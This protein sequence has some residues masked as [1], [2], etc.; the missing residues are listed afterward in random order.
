MLKNKNIIKLLAIVLVLSFALVGCGG[1]TDTSEK[2]ADKG[3]V[4]ILYVEWA[5]ATA[6]SHVMAD[7]LEN[8]M[9]YKVELTPVSAP[10]LFEGLANGDADA[11]TTAWLPITHKSYM[12]KVT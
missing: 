10:L 5:C 1:T 11:M 7:I 6:S 2:V 12:E 9:G 4:K 3:T 8:N